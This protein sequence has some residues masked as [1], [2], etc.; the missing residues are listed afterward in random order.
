VLLVEVDPNERASHGA[1]LA[2]RGYAVEM[3]DA[4]PSLTGVALPAILISDVQSFEALMKEALRKSAVRRLPP[5]VVLAD[6]PHAGVSACLSGADAWVPTHGDGAYLVD[7]VDGLVY[8]F[9]AAARNAAQ[10]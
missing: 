1:T 3:A 8:P 9:T 7:T 5:V 10:A 6:D 2:S 4:W